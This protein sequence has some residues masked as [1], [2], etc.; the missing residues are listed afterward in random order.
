M[1]IRL[2]FWLSNTIVLRTIISDTSAE[3]ELP[4]SAGPG[5]R[6]QKFE[7]ETEKRSSLKWKDSSLSKKNIESFGTWD[8]PVTFITALEKVEAWI[9]S[10]VVESIWWQVMLLCSLCFNFILLTNYNT[11]VLFLFL[12]TLTPRMQSSAASTRE[13]D[14]AN[15]SASKKIFGRTPSSMNQEQGDFSL[16]LWKK[17]FRDAHE[18]LCPLRASGHECG[19]LPVP[20]RL[21]NIS[22][23][24]FFTLGPYS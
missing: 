4:V 14:K 23:F 3:E 22:P 12:Q 20:A 6:Q 8:D 11:H 24:E 10:R 15:G 9:F 1:D 7:R 5:P 21:V 19:C 18:R 17:A 13:F 16:E 2:T